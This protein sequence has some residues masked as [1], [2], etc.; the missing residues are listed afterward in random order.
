MRNIIIIGLVS[1]FTLFVQILGETEWTEWSDWSAC[2]H[3][4]GEGMKYKSRRCNRFDGACFGKETAGENCKEEDCSSETERDDLY[5][6]FNKLNQW[7][8]WSA[9]SQSCAE[10]MKTKSRKCN[11][12]DRNCIGDE[13]VSEKCKEEDCPVSAETERNNLSGFF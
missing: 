6:L 4:C 11:P 8:D 2:L 1:I 7:S 12:F 9:C 5:N 10:G 3:T 13:T